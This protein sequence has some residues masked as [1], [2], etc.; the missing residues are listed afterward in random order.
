MSILLQ[1]IAIGLALAGAVTYLV[2]HYSRRRKKEGACDNCRLLKE[3]KK[4]RHVSPK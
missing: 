1:Q 4:S 2:I 3:A